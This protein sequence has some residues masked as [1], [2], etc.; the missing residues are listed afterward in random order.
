MF[1]TS[2]DHEIRTALL[3]SIQYDEL[4]EAMILQEVQPPLS[5][6][7]A[8]AH[9]FR[10][11]L[12]QHSWSIAFSNPQES[13]LNSYLLNIR[14]NIAGYAYKNITHAQIVDNSV[15][16]LIS[17]QQKTVQYE[18]PILHSL[19]SITITG[20]DT[21]G[22]TVSDYMMEVHPHFLKP[23]PEMRFQTLYWRFLDWIK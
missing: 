18:F 13:N 16:L 4:T 23:L 15:V 22:N 11:E 9:R 10:D 8:A 5:R 7:T 1:G 17:H 14:N 20:R 12:P 6:L 2:P 3:A 19:E 21:T